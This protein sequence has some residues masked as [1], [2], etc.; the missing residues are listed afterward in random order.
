MIIS[1]VTD[2]VLTNSAKHNLPRICCNFGLNINRYFLKQTEK[3]A[4]L[5]EQT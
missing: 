3:Q 1:T 2:I 5:L 4:E